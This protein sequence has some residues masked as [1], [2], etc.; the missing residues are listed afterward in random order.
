MFFG[1][2]FTYFWGPGGYYSSRAADLGACT[3][4]VAHFVGVDSV[5]AGIEE[6]ASFLEIIRT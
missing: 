5:A 2:C 1:I 4:T 3:W 6:A